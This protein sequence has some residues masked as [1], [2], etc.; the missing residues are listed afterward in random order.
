MNKEDYTI[1]YEHKSLSKKILTAGYI[2]TS[3]GL[4]LVTISFFSDYLRSSYLSLVTFA[5]LFS[6]GAGAMFLV[7]LEY[8]TGAVWSIP[9]RRVAEFLGSLVFASPLFL[10][11][12]IINREELY[13]TNNDNVYLYIRL[14]TT[15][16][17]WRIFY[18]LTS[19]NSR[20]QDIKGCQDMTGKNTVIFAVFVVF[21]TIA[22]YVITTDW[23]NLPNIPTLNTIGGLYIFAGAVTT[24]IALWGL[25]SIILKENGY[26]I[27]DLSSDNYYGFGAL[28]FAFTVFWGYIVFIQFLLVRYAN[29]PQESAWFI[30]HS[31]AGWE[32]FFYGL[33]FLQLVLPFSLLLT[34]NAKMNPN[35]L[36]LAAIILITARF[37]DLYWLL[38]PEYSKN[39]FSFN[40]F[41][42]TFL[43]T[44]LGIGMIVFYFTPKNKNWVPIGDPKLK[45]ALQFKL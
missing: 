12:V 20:K 30:R 29:V 8:L 43:L 14:I 6:I 18:V 34:Q 19:K 22:I 25:I 1:G 35:M 9:F 3:T 31:T 15:F 32:Y 13:A 26:L 5:F 45:H 27:N 2:I 23:F 17:I 44:A 41:D 42:F 7:S 11:P 28:L 37:Y 38:I 21:L 16:L 33:L 39:G 36:K 24:S 4:I 10:I 40:I